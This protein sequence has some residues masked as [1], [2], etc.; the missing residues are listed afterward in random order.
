MN[1]NQESAF[2]CVH[3][4]QENFSCIV[5]CMKIFEIATV[6]PFAFSPLVV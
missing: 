3:L 4:R 1:A 5:S 2:I 6:F